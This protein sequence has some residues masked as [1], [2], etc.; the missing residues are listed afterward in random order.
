MTSGQERA[1]RELERLHFA[2]PDSFEILES[3]QLI[4]SSLK[5][6]V[7]LRLGPLQKNAGGLDLKEREE[8]V[9]QIPPD[10][11][12]DQ[13][14]LSVA[15]ERFAGFPHVNWKRY[16]CLYQSNVEWNPADG[17]Y[18]FFDRL[19]LWLKR[20]ALNDMDPV[21]GPLHPPVLIPDW[22]IPPFIIR[23]NMPVE[24]GHSWVGCA[25]LRIPV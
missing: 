12:F 20:A 6:L 4:N 2:D 16:I 15:H 17:L 23:A 3:P 8:F 14:S 19:A 11:P 9:V 13:P 21:E 18:G 7:S 25:E 22:T 24:A 5:V 1:V 10:F